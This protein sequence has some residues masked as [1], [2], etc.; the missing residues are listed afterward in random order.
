MDGLFQEIRFRTAR[1]RNQCRESAPPVFWLRIGCRGSDR[2]WGDRPCG[3][4]GRGE[5]VNLTSFST[6]LHR[7]TANAFRVRQLIA[8]LLHLLPRLNAGYPGNVVVIQT[9]GMLVYQVKDFFLIRHIY[10]L[11]SKS[12]TKEVSLL[13]YWFIYVKNVLTHVITVLK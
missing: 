8:Q 2:C 12:N 10:T 9:L 3:L 13:T 5:I 4:R 6:L 11:T 1:S 7:V